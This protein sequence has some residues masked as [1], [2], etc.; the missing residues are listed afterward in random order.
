MDLTSLLARHPGVTLFDPARDEKEAFKIFESIPMRLPGLNLIYDRSPEFSALLK[1]QAP[2]HQT[3]VA[4]SSTRMLGFA[5]VSWG[6]RFVNGEE[7][8]VSYIGDLR[9]VPN[10]EA[11]STFKNFYPDLLRTAQTE[12]KIDYHLTGILSD[13]KYAIKS[14]VNSP[15]KNQ[16]HYHDL[17]TTTM[18]NVLS[19]KPLS[20]LLSSQL[21]VEK[22]SVAN[23]LP[24]EILEFMSSEEKKKLFGFNL[25]QQEW[26]RRIATWKGLSD[27][28]IYIHR[29]LNGIRAVCI[30]WSVSSIKRMK[31]SKMKT[32]ARLS[33][34]IPEVFGVAVPKDGE[35]LKV[36]Y[37]THLY[38][39]PDSSLTEK[40]RIISQFI[41][42]L[43]KEA[44]A[45]KSTFISFDD[46]WGIHKT[47]ELN[48]FFL[49]TTGVNFY[50]VTLKGEELPDS[51]KNQKIGFEMSLA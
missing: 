14:L 6:P 48:R 22:I 38:F 12:W 49:Q 32:W 20:S 5:S 34:L 31:V 11:L 17:G 27:S 23:S 35:D 16:F 51:F 8:I 24:E 39:A 33:L 1:A 36:P 47:K 10:K 4:R 40:A 30:P 50:G 25:N 15:D 18:V 44:W 26:T 41:R 2:E 9:V 42:E 46:S 43:K 29:N 7:K 3:F 21:K 37:L 19:A 45:R 13:N 28:S